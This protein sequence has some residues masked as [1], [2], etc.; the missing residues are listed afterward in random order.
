MDCFSIS[1][2]NEFPYLF[3]PFLLLSRMLEKVILDSI[4]KGDSHIFC[5]VCAAVPSDVD[6]H[7]DISS[8]S[9]PRRPSAVS[10]LADPLYYTS[11]TIKPLSQHCPDYSQSLKSLGLP[12]EISSVIC[13]GLHSSTRKSYKSLNSKWSIF[14]GSRSFNPYT[15]SVKD[16]LKFL[17]WIHTT[18]K[19]SPKH[20][21]KYH[22]SLHW[23]VNTSF[24]FALDSVLI[25]RYIPGVFN[26]NPAL[27]KL[28][29]DI[30]DI[31]I[32]LNYWDQQLPNMD[33][34]IV[35]LSV[36]TVL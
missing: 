23:V 19:C 18:T 32:V 3:L 27:P 35:V 6:E 20:L 14:A 17:H 31:N 22:A 1:W 16:V 8:V 5:V 36:K 24:H 4:P 11:V 30:W 12:E 33:L 13:H 28:P 15:P 10:P 26:L 9:S 21:L 29:R 25:N 7:A 34:P 2:V